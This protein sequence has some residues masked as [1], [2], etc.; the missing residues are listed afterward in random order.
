MA[1]LSK[2]GKSVLF[3]AMAIG[4][5]LSGVA[6]DVR[7][8]PEGGESE[9]SA[10]LEPLRPGVTEEQVFSEL[11][12]HNERRKSELLGY[13]AVRTYA[14]VDHA[15]KVHAQE[16]GRMEFNAPDK[17]SFFVISEQG[18]GMVRRMALGP[19]IASEVEAASGKEHRD[20]AITPS[21]YTLQLLGEQQVGKYHCFVAQA[22]PKRK[23][24]YLFEGKVWIHDKDF[25]V[26]RIEGRPAKK[27][28][29][30]I[31]RAEFVRRYQK[32]GAFWLPER[33]ETSVHV[34]LYGSKILTIDHGDYVVH[35]ISNRGI[36]ASEMQVFARNEE[37][38]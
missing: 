10:R 15:G 38:D 5:A 30:W 28:S 16:T 21:N 17:K 29:F 32:I 25:A 12:A 4:L 7:A 33:D 27:L 1:K 26:V 31:D 24:K 3:A 23:D 19:L 9:S 18:S 37:T 35:G 13:T 36:S 6:Q 2:K 34:R 20:S 14:V 22:I 8:N 11:L